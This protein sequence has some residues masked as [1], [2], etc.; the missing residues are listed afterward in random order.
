M[1]LSLNSSIRQTGAE[2]ALRYSGEDEG[3]PETQNF[4]RHTQGKGST[5]DV[6][7]GSGADGKYFDGGGGGF[8]GIPARE[9]ENHEYRENKLMEEKKNIVASSP[10]KGQT[11]HHK[12]DTRDGD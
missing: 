3:Y 9:K 12:T 10:T 11:R 6:L 4:P 8:G 2:P 1:R 5:R 7:S